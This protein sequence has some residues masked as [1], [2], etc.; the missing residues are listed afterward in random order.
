MVSY[1]LLPS[2]TGLES[3]S[4]IRYGVTVLEP[5]AIATRKKQEKNGRPDE[6]QNG[7]VGFF[8]V[9]VYQIKVCGNYLARMK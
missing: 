2:N 3:N 4:T 1:G 7:K 5:T 8:S 9:F 6:R